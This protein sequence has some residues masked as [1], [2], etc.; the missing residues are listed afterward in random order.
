[1][2]ADAD[3]LITETEAQHTRTAEDELPAESR[4]GCCWYGTSCWYGTDSDW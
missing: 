2:N 4:E 1:M 3:D